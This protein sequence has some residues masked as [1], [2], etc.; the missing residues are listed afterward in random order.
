MDTLV[1]F[2]GVTLF[3]YLF[4]LVLAVSVLLLAL[5]AIAEARKAAATR[6]RMKKRMQR[7]PEVVARALRMKKAREQKRALEEGHKRTARVRAIFAKLRHP[8]RCQ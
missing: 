6:K 1:R 2:I 8:R 4:L 5:F 3:P 7:R